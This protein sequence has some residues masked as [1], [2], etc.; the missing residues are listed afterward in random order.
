MNALATGTTPVV[1]GGL[2]QKELRPPKYSAGGTSVHGPQY[3]PAALVTSDDSLVHGGVIAAGTRSGSWI[4]MN[5]TSVA[6]P[7][8]ARW[9]ARQMETNRPSDRAAVEGFA[10]NEEL[11]LPDPRPSPERGGA[12]RLR[13][14]HSLRQ[15]RH[16]RIEAD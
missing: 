4:P 15:P 7:R 16:R 3:R 2:M 1:V 13:L 6:G 11:T 12:G 14:P 10:T 5:G 9:I 8:K